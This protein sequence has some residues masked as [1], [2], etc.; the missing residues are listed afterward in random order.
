MRYIKIVPFPSRNF[1]TQSCLNGVMEYQE[2]A[3]VYEQLEKTSKRLEKTHHIAQLL[4]K[5]DVRS[6]GKL[7]LLLQGKVFPP[8]DERKIGMASRMILKAIGIATGHNA[9]ELEQHWAK[10]GDLGETAEYFLGKKK[11][12][13]LSRQDLSVE[14]VFENIRK[15]ALMGGQGSVDR[16]LKL[17][18]ELLTS[19]KPKE[20]KYIVRTVLET[21]RV[22]VG[23]GALRDAIVWAFFGDAVKV[24]YDPKTKNIDPE[25]REKYNEY[26][27]LVQQAYDVTTDFST[28]AEL[29]KEKGE[30]GLQS[31][32]QQI[33]KPLKV[34]LF[35]KAENI[36]KAFERVGKPCVFEYK[37]DGFRLQIHKKDS[38]IWL[39]TRRL[40]EVTK[41][42]PDVVDAV[43]K[44]VKGTNFILDAEVLGHDPKTKQYLPFQTISQRI[45]R[46][47]HIKGMLKKYPVEVNVFDIL[48]YQG[49]NVLNEPFKKRRAMIEKMIRKEKWKIGCAKQLV[50]SSE[51]E[52]ERFYREALA[53][54]QE[55]VMA[56]NL[57]GIYKPGSRVGY[58]VKI[59]PV[60]ETMDLVIVGAEWGEGKRA[61]W[62]SS[63]HIA[64]R[65]PD[66]GELLEIGKVATGFKELEEQG[67]SFKEMTKLLKP[68]ITEKKG[69]H[70][71]VKPKIVIEV[72][73]EEIQKSPTYRSGY[74]LRFPRLVR[75]RDDRGPSDATTL[76]EAKELYKKQKK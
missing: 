9:K 13:T 34:M 61:G 10:S 45:K 60:M 11:Q 73:Y 3:N 4:K 28:V 49:K 37:Y 38:T 71:K 6:L 31:I 68:F 32:T 35:Q 53:A 58:G 30:K 27:D 1:L 51:R 12:A 72:S 54:A 44:H 7:V 42:F 22:G 46:K 57:E 20:A 24:R 39:F 26:I 21:L 70:V 29:A 8:W 76:E 65:D 56:K 69:R 62:L 25:N 75:L 41:Q 16:K 74:A 67:T 15:Q 19:A 59:K 23:E 50:T 33:G 43:K 52:A 55:G 14:K 40:E 48:C 64:C 47:Y 5:T 2:L 66:S 63:Y 17:L 18:A 36:E